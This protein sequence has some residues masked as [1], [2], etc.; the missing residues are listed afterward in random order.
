MEIPLL[1]YDVRLITTVAS[2]I[3]TADDARSPHATHA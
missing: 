3:V 1:A 2:A